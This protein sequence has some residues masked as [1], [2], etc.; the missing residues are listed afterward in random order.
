MG[1]GNPTAHY[2][3]T[4]HNAGFWFLDAV[5]DSHHLA[6]H[7]DPRFHGLTAKLDLNGTSV[8]LLKPTTFM[9]RSGQSVAAL[10]HYLK[11]NP[12]EILVAH[13]EL[14]LP[15]GVVRLKRGGGHGGHNGLRDIISQLGSSDF[16]RLRFGIGHPGDRSAVVD[17]VLHAPSRAENELLQGAMARALALLPDLLMGKLELFMNRLHATSKPRE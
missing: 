9:N 16:Y 4:R 15:P 17:Y 6:F 2:E 10:V 14:D 5:A 7:P 12:V 1:L 11:F 13:D 8:Y 3:K